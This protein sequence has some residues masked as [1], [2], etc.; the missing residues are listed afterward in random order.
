MG[1]YFILRRLELSVDLFF[2]KIV[3]GKAEIDENSKNMLM[4]AQEIKQTMGEMRDVFSEEQDVYL[5]SLEAYEFN[6]KNGFYDKG[7][8]IIEGWFMRNIYLAIHL[9]RY[10]EYF[11]ILHRVERKLDQGMRMLN[12]RLATSK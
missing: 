7:F 5:K 12:F 6:K 1:Y 11:D 10:E 4:S 8:G 9:R 3:E 2:D